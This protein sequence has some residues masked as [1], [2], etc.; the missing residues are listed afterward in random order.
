VNDWRSYDGIAESYERVDAPRTRQVAPD[1]LALA[2]PPGGGRALDVGTGTGVTAAAAREAM[3][4]GA[5]VVGLD[6]SLEMLRAGLAARPGPRV[7]AEAIDLPFRDG[8]FDLVTA[9]FVPQHFTKVETAFFDLVRVLKPGGRLATATWGAGQDELSA[10]WRELVEELV[11]HEL[12]EATFDQVVPG[13]ERFGSRGSVEEVFHDAGLRHVRT[14]PTEY[15][16]TYSVDEY[17]ESRSGG[18]AGRFARDM[19][20]D[21]ALWRSFLERARA[22][23]HERFADPLNDF[24][25]VILAVGTKP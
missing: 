7:A 20:G 6:P 21:D 23:Y 10:T 16:F 2:W 11:P 12:L 19:L 13:W 15:R 25:D 17:V 9:T 24:R 5:L 1:L 18:V 3:G 14:E 4:P 22:V 8:T